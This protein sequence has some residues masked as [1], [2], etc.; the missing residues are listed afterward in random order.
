MKVSNDKI[1]KAVAQYGY[2]LTANLQTYQNSSTER[3]VTFSE[4]VSLGDRSL[5]IPTGT[6]TKSDELYY[7]KS[8]FYDYYSDCQIGTSQ[9][10]GAITDALNY[11]RNTTTI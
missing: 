9:T 7:V 1:R 2:K 8:T 10:P 5:N 3:T 11:S 4:Y 6:Y